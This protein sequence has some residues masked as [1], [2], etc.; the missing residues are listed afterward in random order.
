MSGGDS[1]GTQRVINETNIDPVTQ[2]WRGNIMNAGANLYNRGVPE[3]YPGSTVVPFANQTQQGLDYLQQ[4]AQQGAPNLGAAN[5]ASARALSG[6]NPGQPFALNAA[7]G[8]LSNNPAM[9][10]LSQFGGADNPHL[11]GLWNQGARQVSDAVNAQFAQGGRYASGAHTG[12]LTRELGDL[13]SSIYAPAYEAERNRGLAAA[14]TM[15]G[16]YDTGANRQLAGAELTGAIHSQGNE[17]AAR[18][19]ALLPGLYDYAQMPARTMLGVGG[20]YEGLAQEYLGDDRERYDYTAN[21]PWDYLQRYAGM[22]SGM[23]DFS[24]STQTTQG[25]GTNRAMSALGGAAVG[26]GLAGA[27]GLSGPWG[28]GLAAL[29][30][31][32]GLFG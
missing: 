31:L 20:A 4:H 13:Y 28:W 30:G 2:Q 21:A 10:Q 9:Q 16:L 11:Q 14:Q 1:S 32:G 17:D 24:G 12:T 15:G 19:Q 3:F 25:P 8:G 7:M 27:L 18:A 5:Q 23:P 6:W 26:G 29:G 22:M